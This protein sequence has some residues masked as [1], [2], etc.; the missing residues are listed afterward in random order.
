VTAAL[1]LASASASRLTRRVALL[2]VAVAVTLVAM[3]GWA[4]GASGSVAMLSSLAD[5]ALDL[6]ASLFTFFAVRYAATPPDAEH[7]F[8]HGKAEAFAGLFQAG[9]VAVSAV[10]IAVEAA[11][12]L[13][14]PQPIVQGPMAMAVMAVSIVLTGLLVSAQSWAVKRTGSIATKGDR[15]HY[16]AD[17]AAN[18]AVLAGIAA[19][20]FLGLGW[21]DA[22]AGFFVAV[23]LAWGAFDVAREAADH[24]MDREAPA[25]DRTRIIA[26]AGEDPRIGAVHDLRTRT[27][28]P[29]LHVQMHIELDPDLTLTAAHE[30]V[31]A[32]ET[33]IRAAFPMAD[34]IIHPDPRGAAE[35]HGHEDFE[36]RVAGAG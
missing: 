21:A 11:Q 36:R 4:W 14:D 10:L 28:G 16:V 24:L 27:S 33:R 19:G 20:V 8:G 26:L 35:P 29:Y 22:A 6:A 25:E 18:I 30:L 34:V 15:A 12:R 1:P 13:I 23:W 3:K 31:V 2:S 32:A 5:S 17:F 9:L 7:S